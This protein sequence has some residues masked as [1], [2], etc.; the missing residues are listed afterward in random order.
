MTTNHKEDTDHVNSRLEKGEESLVSG[1]LKP[2][3]ISGCCKVRV[4]CRSNRR[5]DRKAGDGLVIL[6]ASQSTA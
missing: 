6:F 3:V 1:G 5:S 4:R 2:S